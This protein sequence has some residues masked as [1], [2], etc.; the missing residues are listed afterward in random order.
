MEDRLIYNNES[1]TYYVLDINNN[2]IVNTTDINFNIL[3]SNVLN[4]VKLY[5]GKQYSLYNFDYQFVYNLLFNDV[6]I[7]SNSND[8]KNKDGDWLY[9]YY[10]ESGILYLSYFRINTVLKIKYDFSTQIIQILCGNI[11]VTHY[12]WNVV[13]VYSSRIVRGKHINI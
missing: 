13:I 3:P 6:Y 12:K 2:I 8:Y 4:D 7:N 10:E 1:K 11:L 5:L 9:D